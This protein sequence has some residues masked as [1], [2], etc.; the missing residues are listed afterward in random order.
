MAGRIIYLINFFL[1]TSF[2]KSLVKI[3]CFTNEIFETSNELLATAC[4]VNVKKVI[5]SLY[6]NH[7]FF[8]FLRQTC[9]TV[10]GPSDTHP[11]LHHFS[12]ITS[13]NILNKNNLDN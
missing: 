4:S 9:L 8:K 13:W 1:T 3:S 12:N 2:F 11:Y 5:E 7:N 10:L 6:S